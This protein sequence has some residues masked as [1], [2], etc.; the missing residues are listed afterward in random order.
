MVVFL[1]EKTE[2]YTFL[3]PFRN[4]QPSPTVPFSTQSSTPAW[5]RLPFW[6]AHPSC[7][8]LPFSGA[9]TWSMESS[10]PHH[11]GHG[12]EWSSRRS[13]WPPKA[14]TSSIN[15]VARARPSVASTAPAAR[16]VKLARRLCPDRT[17]QP[18]P[19]ELPR[20][21]VENF[22]LVNQTDT[23]AASSWCRLVD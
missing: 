23:C 7:Q 12:E 2:P 15:Q 6:Y 14:K 1:E 5:P 19:R 17:A 22:R 11:P 4:E 13:G 8:T 10:P 20:K 18:M 3:E 16:Q 21:P 9:C